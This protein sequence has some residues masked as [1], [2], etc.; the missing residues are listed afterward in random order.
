[1]AL[2]E[3]D[4][5][6]VDYDGAPALNALTL[7]VGKGQSF[8]IA[9]AAG[10][11]KT[12]LVL[13]LGGLLPPTAN[14]SGAIRFDG[15][16]LPANED[17]VA[18]LR[19]QRIA[20]LFGDGRVRLDPLVPVGAQLAR[21]ERLTEMS[22]DGGLYPHQLTTAQQ[23][24]ALLALALAQE[25]DVLVADEPAHGLDP[26]G[27]REILDLLASL[28]TRIGFALLLLSTDYRAVALCCRDAMVLRSGRAVEFGPPAEVFGRAQHDYTRA[29]VAAGRLRPRTLT[30]SPI[31]TDILTLR[32]VSFA[33]PA[34]GTATL[35]FAIRRGE[36]LAVVAPPRGGKTR[37]ARIVAGLQ[38]APK[39]LLVLDHDSHHGNDLP[40][41]RRREIS[42]V[43]AR[44]ELSFDPR[45]P[46]GNALSEPL[47]LLP[48][49]T[50]EEQA[51]RLV[52]TVRSVGLA[53]ELLRAL[54]GTLTREQLYRFAVARALIARPRMMIIDDPADG[55][56]PE[57]RN[58]LVELLDRV[59][60]DYSLTLL[61]M[62]RDLDIARALADRALVLDNGA[63]V[64]EGH[65]ANLIDAPTHAVTQALSRARLPDVAIAV[66]PEMG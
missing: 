1:M 17:A 8:G 24:R 2:L 33:V 16:V 30:R 49:R 58:G 52:E 29:L 41:S 42:M 11:G 46:V 43:F 53:P 56:D 54:P 7:N 9:G 12:T 65:P 28:Q 18:R 13:A 27:G 50:I 20:F 23:R 44:P 14:R 64:E 38:R 10:S 36:S 57:R 66:T 37:L 39:G 40:L 61:V 59:R 32:D 5:L 63:I 35:N 60:S 25:P 22:V 34:G 3:V 45:Q 21:P 19:G 51:D 4:T 48:H 31:G 6:S 47:R 15:S 26:V 62:T 55:F